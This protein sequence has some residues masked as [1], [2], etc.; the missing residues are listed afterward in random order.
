MRLE[1]LAAV[2]WPVVLGN[3]GDLARSATSRANGIVHLALATLGTPSVLA[4]ITASF[5][6]SGLVHESLFSIEFLL[7]S[8]ENELRATVLTN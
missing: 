1:A 4:R 2:N 7:T 6:A 3:K 8:G 5:A